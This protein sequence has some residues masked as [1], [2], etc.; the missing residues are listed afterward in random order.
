MSERTT[1]VQVDGIFVRFV[2]AIGG[3][4]A[5]SYE[6]IGAYS[7]EKSGNKYRVIQFHEHGGEGNPFGF[8]MR[9]ADEMWHTL[10]FALMAL[11][12]K[13]NTDN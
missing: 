11:H 12:A 7:L 5:T 13:Q 8:R 6:D 3:R 2:K 1:R 9:P 10:D 4:V